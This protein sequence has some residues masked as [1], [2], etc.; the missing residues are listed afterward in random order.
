MNQS[1]E[2][3]QEIEKNEFKRQK[4]KIHGLRTIFS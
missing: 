4:G 3:K 1:S 2:N